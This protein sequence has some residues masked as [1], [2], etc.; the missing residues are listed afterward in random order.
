IALAPLGAQAAGPN[1]NLEGQSRDALGANGSLPVG[2][3]VGDGT[4][5]T[6]GL[7]N[8]REQDW[9]PNRINISGGPVVNQ[10]IVVEIDHS[11][12]MTPGEAGIFTYVATP[13]PA[14]PTFPTGL[15]PATIPANFPADPTGGL[16]TSAGVTA[17]FVSLTPST[18]T[19][20]T[21]TLTYTFNVSVTGAA[22]Q[23]TF[24][25][26]LSSGAHG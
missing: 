5:T 19:P 2:R 11:S 24:M 14:S 7:V 3:G 17:T 15:R 8:W 18:I 1:F 23:V 9:L 22:G 10:Q 4:C 25:T 26:R 6:A 21:T 12:A 13:N 16:Q 20:T